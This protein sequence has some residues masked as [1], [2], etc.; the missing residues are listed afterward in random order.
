VRSAGLSGPCSSPRSTQHEKL[1]GV[2]E[3][4][5][6]PFRQLHRASRTG[7]APLQDHPLAQCLARETPLLE[8][9][10]R[11]MRP[12]GLAQRRERARG[13][14]IGIGL[15]HAAAPPQRHRR[16]RHRLLVVAELEMDARQ[17]ERRVGFGV[18]GANCLAELGDR[19]LGVAEVAS[20]DAGEEA[21][22]GVVRPG[23]NPLFEL[24]QCL[25]GFAT[26]QEDAPSQQLCVDRLREFR[27]DLLGALEVAEVDQDVGVDEVHPFVRII[28]EL[29]NPLDRFERLLR[30]GTHAI[31]RGQHVPR[32]RGIEA[33]DGLAQHGPGPL[34]ASERLQALGEAAVQLEPI[35]A[36]FYRVAPQRGS[37]LGASGAVEEADQMLD[38]DRVG[39]LLRSAVAV[40]RGGL[41]R[42][43]EH[44][45]GEDGRR[46]ARAAGEGRVVAL[47]AHLL[48]ELML[49][50]RLF[51]TAEV[52]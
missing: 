16:G 13:D 26:Q 4:E 14:H 24:G 34:A 21:R 1:L 20:G 42:V 50:L 36:G 27:G 48:Q 8:A 32:R 2:G 46:Q 49:A 7:E 37:P 40:E 22:C 35:G 23:A 52:A 47:L 44:V 30:L 45:V 28:R 31:E 25:G 17:F 19:T 12:V 6:A 29:E 18:V 3:V 10:D 9:F 41:L 5:A 43:S 51:E 38:C 15:L 39:R 33:L 11:T